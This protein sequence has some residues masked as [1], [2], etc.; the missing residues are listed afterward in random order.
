MN[1]GDDIDNSLVEV[2][3]VKDGAK[4]CGECGAVQV[5]AAQISKVENEQIATHTNR[6]QASGISSDLPD[7]IKGWSWGA[8]F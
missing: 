8:F 5:S 2:K 4:F 1:Y 6:N 3:Q 7:G